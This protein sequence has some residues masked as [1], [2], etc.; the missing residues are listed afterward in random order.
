MADS[1]VGEYLNQHFVSS[2][3]KVGSFQLVDGQKQGGNV[4]S[5]FCTPN[6][7]ILDA[8]AG[9]V[10]AATL[11]REARWVEEAYKLGLLE[12]KS[13]TARFKEFFRQAHAERLRKEY[14]LDISTPNAWGHRRGL[15][16]Q[17][18]VHLLMAA[19]PTAK[20]EQVY[21]LV[22]EKILNEKVSTS[23]VVVAG[24]RE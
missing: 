4:V 5:Y 10:D 2:F 12:G 21:K 15:G 8:V 17:G 22:F 7:G 19:A 11:L 13:D 24:N 23:P 20:V 14:G 3:Q 18:R 6:G 9:P 16:N 1:K